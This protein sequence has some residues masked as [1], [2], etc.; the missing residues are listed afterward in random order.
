MFG[1]VLLTPPWAFTL[2]A[3][4]PLLAW[5]Q[6]RKGGRAGW[7]GV[8]GPAMGAWLAGIGA[9]FFFHYSDWMFSYLFEARMTPVGW[10]YPLF[11][12]AVIGAGAAGSLLASEAV[13][14]GRRLRAAVLPL[15]G[16]S[17]LFALAAMTRQQI[18]HVG[19]TLEFRQEIALPFQEVPPFQ[20]ALAG[21]GVL[22]GVPTAL[23]ILIVAI[24][25][26]RTAR[27]GAPPPPDLPA[28]N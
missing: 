2:G 6:I 21:A 13:L 22:V 14:A 3:L 17:W 26:W 12:I 27:G 7:Y 5:P 11:V 18:L 16:L 10:F 1:T 25:A 8:L 19:S 24:D 9:Y 28:S 4:L 15:I 23:L 20:V